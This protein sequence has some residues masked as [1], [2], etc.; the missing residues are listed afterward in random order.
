MSETFDFDSGKGHTDENFPVGSVLIAA[1]HRPLVMAFYRVARMSDDVADHP[2]ASPDQKLA[3]LDAIG[4]TLTGADDAVR[5]AVA[6][7]TRHV[8][9]HP[10]TR[11]HEPGCL[12]DV[13]QPRRRRQVDGTRCADRR[14]PLEGRSRGR[15]AVFRGR[16]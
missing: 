1:R 13:G 10:A 3:R 2:T 7:R 16:A 8:L 15:G 11:Q 14:A 12:N 6:L 5:E 9:D 4:A